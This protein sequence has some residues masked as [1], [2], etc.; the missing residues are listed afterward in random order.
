MTAKRTKTTAKEQIKLLRGTMTPEEM[1]AKLGVTKGYV[2]RVLQYDPGTIPPL[3]P[4]TYGYAIRWGIRRKEDLARYFGVCRMTINR[5]ENRPEMKR[6]MER[7]KSIRK[8]AF[9]LDNLL[10]ELADKL[11]VLEI[12]EPGS[13][14]TKTV[15]TIVEALR[16]FDKNT[17]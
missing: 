10:V 11:E 3:N 9:Y 1:A 15:R 7:Y 12:F 6:L 4:R 8:D 2:E 5:F 17:N 16:K 13:E 14:V